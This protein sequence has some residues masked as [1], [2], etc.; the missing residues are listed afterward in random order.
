MCGGGGARVRFMPRIERTHHKT[1]IK[2]E[3]DRTE[4]IAK[5][6]KEHQKC[7]FLFFKKNTSEL[8]RRF[9]TR[10]QKKR[11]QRRKNTAELNQKRKRNNKCCFIVLFLCNYIVVDGSH[12]PV[13]LKHSA[14]ERASAKKQ[15]SYQTI[16]P[17]YSYREEISPKELL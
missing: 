1:F 10:K 11:T 9:L 12:P 5:R 4:P 15:S 14:T 17:L 3:P 8:N 16:T 2:R 7:I 13:L 6:N